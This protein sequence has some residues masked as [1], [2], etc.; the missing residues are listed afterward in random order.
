M[1][2]TALVHGDSD[3]QYSGSPN[4]HSDTDTSMSAESTAILSSAAIS[5]EGNTPELQCYYNEIV[6]IVDKLFA[7]SILIRGTSP[8][9]RASRAAA[10]VQKDAEGIDVIAEFKSIVAL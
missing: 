3:F 8:N 4:D 7:V 9:F 5:D 6:S 1:I 2:G 10:H